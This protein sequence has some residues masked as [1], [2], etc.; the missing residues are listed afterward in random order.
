MLKEAGLSDIPAMFAEAVIEGKIGVGSLY[1]R[2][3]DDQMRNVFQRARCPTRR[4]GGNSASS[5][6]TGTATYVSVGSA[7][8]MCVT[9]I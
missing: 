4:H 9:I 5:T 3:T 8:T 1:V 2:A 7:T 6:Q